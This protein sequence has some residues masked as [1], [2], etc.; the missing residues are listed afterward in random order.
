[1]VKSNLQFTQRNYRHRLEAAS[2]V[3]RSTSMTQGNPRHRKKKL[4]P[5]SLS[6]SMTA[7]NFRAQ[8]RTWS[9]MIQLDEYLTAD[10]VVCP[11]Q[12]D[13]WPYYKLK[14][15]TLIVLY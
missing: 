3:L 13:W 1:M 7:T 10:Q 4:G 11:C 2:L 12:Q 15:G 5:R 9:R 14:Q 6:K 8:Q